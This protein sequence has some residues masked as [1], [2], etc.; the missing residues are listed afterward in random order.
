MKEISVIIIITDRY[1]PNSGNANVNIEVFFTIVLYQPK[2]YQNKAAT[3][4]NLHFIANAT[5]QNNLSRNSCFVMIQ[6]R[7]NAQSFRHTVADIY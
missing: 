5:F 4:N 3:D 6:R 2:N 1:Q 7:L